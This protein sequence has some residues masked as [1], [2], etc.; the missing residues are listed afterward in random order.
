ML[1][2][3]QVRELLDTLDIPCMQD[4]VSIDASFPPEHLRELKAPG[5]Y[6]VS[7]LSDLRT[8]AVVRLRLLWLTCRATEPTPKTGS[9]EME[10]R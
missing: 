3:P 8:C 4:L 6:R 7:L 5:P 10:M 1:K 9:H 2:T